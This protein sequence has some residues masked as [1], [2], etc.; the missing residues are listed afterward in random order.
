MDPQSDTPQTGRVVVVTG[1]ARGIGRA[2]LQRFVAGGDRVVVADVLPMPADLCESRHVTYLACDLSNPD[3]IAAFA[4]Q[5]LARFGHVDVLVNNAA[6]GFQFVDLLHM[7]LAHWERVQ[8]TNLR[9]TV[10]LTQALLKDMVARQAGVIVNIAS[11]AAFQ[12]EAGHSAY[13]ASKAGLVALTKC[14]AREVGRHGIRV[15]CVAPG[16]IATENNIPGQA[17]ALWLA[18]NV[19]LGRA[20]TPEEVAEVVWFV[21]SSAASYITGQCIIV[22]GGGV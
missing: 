20:G 3:H 16:W 18:E 11:C 15:V 1:A 9:G 13:A 8:D 19:S 14:L 22:D 6:T 12:A 4:D 5:T 21:A 2:I 7:D 17:D 10:L